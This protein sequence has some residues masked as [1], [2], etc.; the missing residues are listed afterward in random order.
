MRHHEQGATGM[1]KVVLEKLDGVDVKMIGGLV[2][3]VE[4]SLAGKHND[5]SHPFDLATG[6]SPHQPRRIIQP[7]GGK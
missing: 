3:D 4:I 1:G 5:D 7:E 2:K 6:K